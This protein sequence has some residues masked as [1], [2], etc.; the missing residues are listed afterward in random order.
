MKTSLLFATALCATAAWAADF[1]LAVPDSGDAPPQGGEAV[2]DVEATEGLDWEVSQVT[3]NWLVVQ[4]TAG[5]GDGRVTYQVEPNPST[6]PRSAKIRLSAHLPEPEVDLSRGLLIWND[7]QDTIFNQDWRLG[8]EWKTDSAESFRITFHT[9]D[10]FRPVCDFYGGVGSLYVNEQNQFIFQWRD[11]EA[12][13]LPYT[14]E[15]EKEYKIFFVRD[16]T[17][18]DI[19]IG[20]IGEGLA[21]HLLRTETLD[22]SSPGSIIKPIEATLAESDGSTRGGDYWDRTISKAEVDAALSHI[23]DSRPRASKDTAQAPYTDLAEFYSLDTWAHVQVYYDHNNHL[24]YDRFGWECG[25]YAGGLR[26][27]DINAVDAWWKEANEVEIDVDV[28]DLGTAGSALSAI[29]NGERLAREAAEKEIGTYLENRATSATYSFWCR[30]NRF[31]PG[32][33]FSYYAYKRN[34]EVEGGYAYVPG[35]GYRTN[36]AYYTLLPL[37]KNPPVTSCVTLDEGGHLGLFDTFTEVACE[38]NRWHM[39]TVSIDENSYTLYLDGEQILTTTGATFDTAYPEFWELGGGRTV[40]YIYDRV[41]PETY[42]DLSHF[43]KA[44]T[45]EEVKALYETEKPLEAVYTVN[46]APQETEMRGETTQILPCEGAA[47]T[48]EVSAGT[49]QQWDVQSNA[50]W[51]LASTATGQ[52]SATVLFSVQPNPS[53]EERTTTVT[54]AGRE[55]TVTQRGYEAVVTP[56]VPMTVP[57]RSA[58]RVFTVTVPSYIDWEAVSNADWIKIEAGAAG[59]GNGTVQIITDAVTDAPSGYSRMGTLTIAGQTVYVIQ[60]NFD[61]SLSPLTATY[62][63]A[64]GSGE[65]D[66]NVAEGITWTID[67]TADW[68]KVTS[69]PGT[70]HGTVTYTVEPNKT[71]EARSAFIIVSGSYHTVTQNAE[72][73]VTVET[74]GE[75][76]VSGGGAVPG[77]TEVTLTATPAEGY[78]F[79]HWTGDAEGT[80]NPLTFTAEGTMSVVAH[81][82]PQAAVDAQVNAAIE[83]GGYVTKD[84]VKD[85]SFGAP[86]IDVEG[87][88]VKVGIRLQSAS[89]LS[90]EPTWET[91]KPTAA[92]TDTDGVIS[93]TLPREGNAAFYRFLSPEPEEEE[94]PAGTEP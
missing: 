26:S 76:S 62:K 25:A 92:E 66:V 57:L 22:P 71:G 64:G 47:F 10:T 4:D 23:S 87:D 35:G 79:S 27:W 80:V 54:V 86:I 52:G 94:T 91:L 32:T 2:F 59:M 6:A 46:Q 68:M 40:E 39:V 3:D 30:W 17:G 93:V 90:G 11:N 53:I 55:I 56:N 31:V 38:L 15:T 83:A 18:T 45:A 77:G 1:Q 89:S 21:T 50:D 72:S 28:S 14:F 48:V 16:L 65:I 85:L 61:L 33:I 8:R 58:M 37:A 84:Q 9:L 24:T 20:A 43:K 42:D 60:R 75:G 7:S 69:A 70:G 19:Y 63:S 44:L 51:V 74:V 36:W 73:V 82:V 88:S 81:F 41:I 49:D 12:V 13:I 67:A 78:V 29:R 5:S 34:Y